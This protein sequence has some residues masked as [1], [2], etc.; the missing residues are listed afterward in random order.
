MIALQSM[1]SFGSS[2]DGFLNSIRITQKE[3]KEPVSGSLSDLQEPSSK[4]IL[5]MLYESERALEFNAPRSALVMAWAALEASL[6]RAFLRQG[7]HGQIG[8][9]PTVLIR[10]LLSAGVLSLDEVRLLER[11]RQLRTASVHGLAPVDFST[12]IILEMNAISRRM[13]ADNEDRRRQRDIIDIFAIDSIEGYSV[14]VPDRLYQSLWAF[15]MSKGLQGRVKKNAIKDDE[16]QHDIQIQKT[17]P[18]REFNR[19]VNKWKEG[20]ISK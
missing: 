14:L 19:L 20:Y 2:V 18:F 17:I 8:V 6:R 3:K 5:D 11:L 7:R 12:H 13:L 9:Q 4:Q 15:L 10:E 16:P 1:Q